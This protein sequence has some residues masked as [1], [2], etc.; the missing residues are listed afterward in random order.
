ML[1]KLYIWSCQEQ[2]A[3]QNHNTKIGNKSFEGVVQYRYVG[4]ILTNQKSIHYD[5]G[6][7][8]NSVNHSAQ[9]VASFSFL[10]KNIKIK[11]HRTTVLPVVLSRC[12]TF[13][14]M[15]KVYGNRV[16]R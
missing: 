5:I 9:N 10:S 1:I 3:G 15:L 16:L 7:R 12:E 6:S 13:Y 11:I 2:P 8:L 4:T 14:L